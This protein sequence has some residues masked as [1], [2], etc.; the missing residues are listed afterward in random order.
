[1]RSLLFAPATKPELVAKLADRGADAVVFDLEDAVPLGAKVTARP[2]ARAGAETLLAQ[3]EGPAVWIR[4]NAVPTEWFEADVAEAIPRGVAGV[5]VPKVESGEQVQVVRAALAAAHLAEL[6]IMAGIETAAG[7]VRADALLAP[8]VTHAYFGAE[9]YISDLGGVRTAHNQEVL[10][11]RSRV[12]LAA[13]VG[14][15]HALDQV[16]TDFG[17]D[18]RFLADAAEGAMLGYRGKLCIHPAQVTLAH[19]AF[20][21]SAED[22]ARARALL[23]AYE[24]AAAAGQGAIAFDGQMVDEPLARQARDIVFRAGGD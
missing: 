7:V 3:P 17:D 18:R 2:Q 4:V 13:R 12:A 24:D 23:A 5:V 19:Q 22:V 21:P 16:V 9:D 8:P 6:A 14:G 11:A 20:T 1:M 15:V 10:Y